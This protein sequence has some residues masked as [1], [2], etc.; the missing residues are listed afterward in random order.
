MIYKQVHIIHLRNWSTIFPHESK[1]YSLV[2]SETRNWII[3]MKELD[4]EWTRELGIRKRLND[5]AFH[6][7][8]EQMWVSMWANTEERAINKIKLTQSAGLNVLFFPHKDTNNSCFVQNFKLGFIFLPQRKVY[9][10]YFPA[11]FNI[12]LHNKYLMFCERCEWWL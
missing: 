6:P 1:P 10:L 11:M 2:C 12:F 9:I 8:S 5:G 7:R 3:W 4:S